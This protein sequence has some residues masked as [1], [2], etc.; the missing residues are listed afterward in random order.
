MARCSYDFVPSVDGC[1]VRET[2]VEHR[3]GWLV[4]LD[5]VIFGI[6]DRGE[7]NRQTMETTLEQLG[8]AL[9]TR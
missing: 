1:T 3:P 5:P 6:A 8:D 4:R 2:W 9:V 7:H